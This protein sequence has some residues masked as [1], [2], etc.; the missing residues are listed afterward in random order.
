MKSML[1]RLFM[2]ISLILI[3]SS[4]SKEDDNKIP[5]FPESK[6]SVIHGDD[7]RSWR[8]VEVI[9]KSVDAS[10][11]TNIDLS[12]VADDIYT[13]FAN[14]SAGLIELGDQLCFQEIDGDVFKADMEIFDCELIYISESIYLRYS[15]GYQNEEGT[16]S[17][18]LISYYALAELSENKMVFYREG[19]KYVG[20]FNEALIFERVQ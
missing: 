8:I 19:G 18:M 17:G 20:E 1:S 3:I 6:M 7:E 11:D 10:S 14:Q 13:F 12:C 16:A 5:L 15:R 4:C 9:D 2:A